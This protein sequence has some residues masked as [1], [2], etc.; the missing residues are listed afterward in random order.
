MKLSRRGVFLSKYLE[1]G[2]K[3]G[4]RKEENLLFK[5]IMQLRSHWARFKHVK[6]RGHV[7]RQHIGLLCSRQSLIVRNILIIV[8]SVLQNSFTVHGFLVLL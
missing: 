5:F 1:K 2:L 8:Q 7:G 4:K 6:Q 3:Y